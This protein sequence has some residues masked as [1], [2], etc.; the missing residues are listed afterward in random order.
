MS[1]L[2]GPKFKCAACGREFRWKPQL[3]G[4][5]AKCKCGA[6]IAVPREAPGAV[7]EEDP[8]EM[9]DVPEPI[10]APSSRRPS[11]SGANR[12]PP[13]LPTDDAPQQIACPICSTPAPPTAV[14]CT[15]CGYNFRTG[16]RMPGA[17]RVVARAQTTGG[18]AADTYQ[19]AA[20]FSWM[21]PLVAILLG[22]CTVGVRSAGPSVGLAIAGLQLLLI[23]G[24]LAAGIFAL[25]GVKRYGSESILMPAI[26]GIVLNGL[27]IGLNIFLFSMLLSGKGPFKKGA[28]GVGGGAASA[29]PMT[30][31]Q[32]KQQGEDAFLQQAG[33][34]G[35][36]PYRGAAITLVT[37]PDNS[38]LIVGI[39][40]SR[41]GDSFTLDPTGATVH[42][43]DGTSKPLPDVVGVLQSAR[44]DREAALKAFSPPFEVMPGRQLV[45]KFMFLPPRTDPGTIA[46]V[47]VKIDGR[48]VSVP[49]RFMTADQKQSAV[50]AGG[51][52]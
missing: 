50:E 12:P 15:A 14:L 27:I 52:R 49:G 22:C 31:Q 19:Q 23:L 51:G 35:L 3:A 38:P 34:V 44:T 43:A 17:G 48:P 18:I 41:G 10:A 42:F 7:L 24:G 16:M 5:K 11:G 40:N 6:A 9:A 28:G 20:K 30:R 45:G 29:A 36:L 21:A 32:I 13:P 47:T 33:W 8:F 2:D 37:V 26:T 1:E 46:S 25:V 39:D 4:K